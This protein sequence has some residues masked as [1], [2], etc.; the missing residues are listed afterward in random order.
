MTPRD[1]KKKRGSKAAGHR[2][3]LPGAMRS[4][5]RPNGWPC[6]RLHRRQVH[7]VHDRHPTRPASSLLLPRSRALSLSLAAPPCA[8][9]R[10]PPRYFAMAAMAS[11]AAVAA[12][13][14]LASP[15][16]VSFFGLRPMRPLAQVVAFP[17][18]RLSR[19]LPRGI[20]AEAA[21]DSHFN[22]IRDII[23]EQLAVKPEVIKQE[24]GEKIQTVGHAVDLIKEV[25]G[26]K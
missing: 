10:A 18:L 17:R 2:D 6:P 26:T 4:R 22:D 24:A 21:Q 13:A 8:P 5:A 25:I 16:S 20:R 1:R 3:F 23:A 12:S 15:A 11:L 9:S 19:S 7:K 14:T